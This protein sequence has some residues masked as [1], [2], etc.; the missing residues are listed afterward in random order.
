MLEQTTQKKKDSPV[1]TVS[2]NPMRGNFTQD[3]FHQNHGT[4]Y[5]VVEEFHRLEEET[6]GQT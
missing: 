5:Q 1:L 2:D 4:Q 6:R 3:F